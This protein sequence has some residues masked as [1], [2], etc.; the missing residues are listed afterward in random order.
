MTTDKLIDFTTLENNEICGLCDSEIE[1]IAGFQEFLRDDSAIDSM[2][3]DSFIAVVDELNTSGNAALKDDTTEAIFSPGHTNAIIDASESNSRFKRRLNDAEINILNTSTIPKGTIARNKWA[4]NIFNEWKLW[5]KLAL[6]EN[7]EDWEENDLIEWLPKFLHEIRKRDGSLYPNNSIYSIIAG[8]QYHINNMNHNS[9]QKI[10]FFSDFKF[11]K[12]TESLDSAMKLS[13]KEVGVHTKRANIISFEEENILWEKG[14]LGSESPKQLIKTLFFYNGL[15]FAVRGGDEHRSLSIDQFSIEKKPG[16]SAKIIYKE[17]VTKT[18]SGGLKCRRLE[19]TVKE[20]YENTECPEKCHVKLF[21]KY[22]S[23]RPPNSSPC[24]YLK[25]LNKVSSAG[26]GYSSTS[27][28]GVNTLKQ[29][30]K[31]MFEDAGLKA[32]TNHSLKATCATRMFNS[33]IDEQIIMAK[34]G[35]R[36]I[37]GVRSYK[38][39]GDHHLKEACITIDGRTVTNA[40]VQRKDSQTVPKITFNITAQN[41]TVNNY[42]D[43]PQTMDL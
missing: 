43:K 32:K 40:Y 24:F 36:S 12:I 25:P 16:N 27:K 21:E 35:H 29:M 6:P 17:N 42:S 41:V 34:T 13:S 8:L 22:L 33:G 39:I 7:I 3:N 37:K 9:Q 1:H 2:L 23:L 28:I 26:W 18:F 31:T 30:L 38:R 15:H 19:P 14:Q 4:I 20:H 5:R 10:N 11:R